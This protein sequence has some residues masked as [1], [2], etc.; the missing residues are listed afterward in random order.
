MTFFCSCEW[1]FKL[2]FLVAVIICVEN[3]DA[4]PRVC[5][6]YSDDLV[7]AQE[8][9]SFPFL[10]IEVEVMYFYTGPLIT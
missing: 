7:F 6:Q 4:S 10:E 5:W 1:G 8:C 2:R 9:N 3:E